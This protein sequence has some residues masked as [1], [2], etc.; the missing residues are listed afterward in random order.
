MKVWTLEDHVHFDSFMAGYWPSW[1]RVPMPTKALYVERLEIRQLSAVQRALKEVKAR[2]EVDRVPGLGVIQAQV[3]DEERESVWRAK[4]RDA[5]SGATFR[6][7]QDAELARLAAACVEIVD[8][9]GR[10]W[11]FVHLEDEVTGAHDFGLDCANTNTWLPFAV[12]RDD[13]QDRLR[14]EGLQALYDRNAP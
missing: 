5:R 4:S 14:L 11:R 6:T 3:A 1:T 13:Q 12:L 2:Q 10:V 9:A 8:A 7:P